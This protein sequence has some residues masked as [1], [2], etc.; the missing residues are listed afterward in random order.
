M[1]T[2]RMTLEFTLDPSLP[3]DPHNAREVEIHNRIMEAIRPYVKR[4]APPSLKLGA[5]ATPA[6]DSPRPPRPA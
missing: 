5:F 4:G 3:P 2:Y 1:T 6:D